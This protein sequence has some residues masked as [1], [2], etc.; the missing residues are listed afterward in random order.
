MHHQQLVPGS[1]LKVAF[2]SPDL[3]EAKPGL[4]QRF[5][6]GVAAQVRQGSQFGLV[7]QG[8]LLS[9][10]LDEQARGLP[11]LQA[12]GRLAWRKRPGGRAP[13][14]ET[15]L[16][17]KADVQP[18]ELSLQDGAQGP[19]AGARGGLERFGRSLL[20]LAQSRQPDAVLR[21]ARGRGGA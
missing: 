7:P 2:V 1:G 8:Q 5:P 18:A 12:L 21:P 19:Q 17:G 14:R 15:L 11:L 9:V 10:H 4:P 16:L 20:R 13:Q 3:L 6:L